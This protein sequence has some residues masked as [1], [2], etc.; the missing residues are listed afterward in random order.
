MTNV[1][2]HAGAGA[3]ELRLERTGDQVVLTVRDDGRGLP[4]G[5]R[6]SHGI[7]GMRERAMLIGAAFTIKAAPERRHR[8]QARDPARRRSTM[9]TPPVGRSRTAGA[10]RT[11][12]QAAKAGNTLQA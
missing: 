9:T 3:V 10:V 7:R 5:A 4:R 1:A 6:S 12:S 8:G 11:P 2:R